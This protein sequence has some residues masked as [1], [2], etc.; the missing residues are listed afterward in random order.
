MESA[1]SASVSQPCA[2]R[3]CAWLPYPS[4]RGCRHGPLRSCVSPPF[5]SPTA[6]PSCVRTSWISLSCGP[7]NPPSLEVNSLIAPSMQDMRG[8]VKPVATSSSRKSRGFFH[9]MRRLHPRQGVFC[10]RPGVLAGARF[11]LRRA[12]DPRSPAPFE[13]VIGARDIGDDGHLEEEEQDQ[14]QDA[15]KAHSSTYITRKGSRAVRCVTVGPR[16]VS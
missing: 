13:R 12:P 6:S 11:R 8:F 3:P 5:S 10:A 15:Q 1:L 2:W 7:S 4:W 9:E 16:A 14:Q